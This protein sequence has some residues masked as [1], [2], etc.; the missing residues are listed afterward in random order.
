MKK[1]R[2]VLNTILFIVLGGANALAGRL[3]VDDFESGT[4]DKWAVTTSGIT[5]SDEYARSGS[6]SSKVDY[7]VGALQGH[8]ANLGETAPTDE[9]YVCYHVRIGDN[10][11]AP[12]LGFKWLRTKHGQIDGIQ[13]EFY[14]NSE[15]WF[16]SGHSYQTGQGGLDSPGTGYSWY[17]DF[18]DGD[19]HKIEV[20]G[21]YNI[22][23]AANGI[24]R[25]WFDGIQYANFTDYTWRAGEWSSDI[26]R[27][28]YI[29]S[30]AGDGTHSAAA[31]DIIY[32][33]DVEIWDGMPVEGD[34]EETTPDS[35]AEAPRAPSNLR[36]VQ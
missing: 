34:D 19:W 12:Y 8:I 15:S 5:N 31:G 13:T 7:G 33:D 6:R 2:L 25:V 16:S 36:V 21:K 23:G 35:D 24:C 1:L 9:F 10:Y 3:F 20:F 28:F 14:L 26:F 22:D 17:P 11:N 32:I 29:P 18:C 30:N 27:L 4:F